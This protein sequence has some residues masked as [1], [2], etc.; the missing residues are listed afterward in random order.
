LQ[1]L[2]NEISLSKWSGG[3]QSRRQRGLWWAKPSPNKPPRPQFEVLN[4]TNQLSLSNF[5]M[6]NSL[7]YRRK[8]PLLKTLAMI[9]VV[10]RIV[11]T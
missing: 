9:L 1:V 5:K 6:S 2:K 7:A 4:T 11:V 3:T 8:P 10:L